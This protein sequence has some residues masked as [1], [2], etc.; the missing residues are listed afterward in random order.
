MVDSV[1]VPGFINDIA[2]D[3]TGA[4]LDLAVTASRQGTLFTSDRFSR[5][6]R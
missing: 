2:Y 6:T 5:M 3:S 1:S 4:A